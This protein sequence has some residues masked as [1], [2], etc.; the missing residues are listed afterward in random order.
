MKLEN[1]SGIVD[2]Y[3][4]PKGDVEVMARYNQPLFLAVKNESESAECWR[5]DYSRYLYC[6]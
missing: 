5:Y 2:N 3:R 6:K 1:H 4:Y